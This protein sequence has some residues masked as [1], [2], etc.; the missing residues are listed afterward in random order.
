MGEQKKRRKRMEKIFFVIGILCSFFGC[1][2]ESGLG[3][4]MPMLGIMLIMLSSSLILAKAEAK[5][6]K[7]RKRRRSH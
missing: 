3:L 6:K 5:R 7:R 1:K 2:A 4:A